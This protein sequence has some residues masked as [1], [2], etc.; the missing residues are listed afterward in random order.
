MSLDEKSIDIYSSRDKIRTELIKY[1]QEHL[2]L[3][4]V[5]LTKT[6]YLS[7]LVNTLS[8]LTSNLLFYNSSV[9]KEMFLT[10]ATLKESVL[11]LAAMLSYTPA[12]ATTATSALLIEIPLGFTSDVN[13][14]LEKGFKYYANDVIFTQNNEIRLDIK[15]TGTAIVTEIPSTGGSQVVI[16]SINSNTL[17]FAVSVTQ[18]EEIPLTYQIPS[19][20]PFEFYTLETN[21]DGQ[22]S[23]MVVTT[24]DQG[25][26]I[27]ETWISYNSLFLIP[28]GIRGFAFRKTESGGRLFFGNGVVGIQPSENA[29]VTISMNITKGSSGNVISGSIVKAQR[30]YVEDLVG[31]KLIRKP[32]QITVTNVSPATGGADSPT[33][34]EIRSGAITSLS[35][36]GRLVSQSDYNNIKDIVTN[37]ISDHSIDIVKRSDLKRNEICVFSDILFQGLI[38]PTRNTIWNVDSTAGDSTAAVSTTT[39]FVRT[40]DVASINNA[41]YYS[42]FNIEI[43]PLLKE[44]NYFYQID[45]VEKPLVLSR[46]YTTETKISLDKVKFHVDSTKTNLLIDLYF[47]EIVAAT[48]TELSCEMV[49]DWDG[50]ERQMVRNVDPAPGGGFL[51]EF[52]V[53][54]PLTEPLDGDWNY[55]FRMYDLVAGTKEYI[56]ESYVEITVKKDLSDFMYSSVDVTGTPGNY[57]ITIYDVPVIKKSWYDTTNADSFTLNVLE[58]IIN[59]DVTSYRMMT[60]FLNLKFSNTTGIL[61]NMHKFN[62][63]DKD[64]VIS[65]NPE[66]KPTSPLN[67]DRYLITSEA[68][69]IYSS[70]VVPWN[71]TGTRIGGFIVQYSSS[72]STWAYE[73]LDIND[74]IYVVDVGSNLIYNGSSMVSMISMIP[75]EI[76]LIIWKDRSVSTVDTALSALIKTELIAALGP[77]FGFDK[78]LYTSQIIKIVQSIKGV[79]NVKVVSPRHDIFFSYDKYKD[80]SEQDLLE[81]GPDLIYF[82]ADQISIEIR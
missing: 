6:S 37:F 14:V 50:V 32:V 64:P 41:D 79:A 23:S 19:L 68:S 63:T 74:I 17:I 15:S 70:G 46:T 29:T 30:V 43:N 42:M 22:I 48:Y 54:I 12:F 7:Y 39:E 16:S 38:V 61:S 60:D 20:K 82:S 66:T 80:F 27:S 71:E 31:T 58:K 72:T 24:T 73:K 59:L 5:D 28:S 65:V 44:A 67:G 25:S 13:I 49:A 1:M 35:S 33:M 45:S 57:N 8:V 53:S 21:F 76:S 81:Y 77:N 62:P 47:T 10:K 56:N 69:H 36:R 18:V 75:L 52:T 9:Y 40:N 4:N 2:E 34:D 11:N 3:E 55:Y 51:E 26:Q 78:G